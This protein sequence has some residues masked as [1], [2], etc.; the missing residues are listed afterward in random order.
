MRFILRNTV[1]VLFIALIVCNVYIFISGI[2]LSDEISGFDK[3]IAKLHQEN[4]ELEKKL[5]DVSSLHYAASVAAQLS[6]TEKSNP[7]YWESLKFALN[8]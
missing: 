5:Y 2:T 4:L 7:I 3:N 6:F 8:R 1:W